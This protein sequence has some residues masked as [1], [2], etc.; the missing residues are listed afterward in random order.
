MKSIKAFTLIEL[1]VVISI[2]A[3]LLSILMPSLGK[4][5]EQARRVACAANQKQILIAVETYAITHDQWYPAASKGRWK[6]VDGTLMACGFLKS[7][8][9]FQCPTDNADFGTLSTALKNDETG[10]ETRERT[11]GNYRTYGFNLSIEGWVTGRSGWRRPEE[12]RKPAT[13]I[14]VSETPTLY[15]VLYSNSYE[16]YFGPVPPNLKTSH[17][18]ISGY[19][20]WPGYDIWAAS[21]RQGFIHGK[22]CNYGFADGHAEYLIVDIEKEFPPFDWFDNGLCRYKKF[23]LLP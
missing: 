1:L 4:A 17:G 14:F 3:V 5:R 7:D 13:T 16:S 2:I 8:G 18:K 21:K 15:N 19:K 11:R 10:E 20:H 9:T 12:V 22:G 23:S 6:G